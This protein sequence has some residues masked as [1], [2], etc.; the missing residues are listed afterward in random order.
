MKKAI[1]LPELSP[2]DELTNE[3]NNWLLTTEEIHEEF[4]SDYR[5]KFLAEIEN[6]SE[7]KKTINNLIKLDKEGKNIVLLCYCVPEKMCHRYIIGEILQNN[8]ANVLFESN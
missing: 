4:T 7:A 2:S 3:Q 6:N 5:Q 8:G 1:H